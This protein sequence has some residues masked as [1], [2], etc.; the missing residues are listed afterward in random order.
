MHLEG[1]QVN[2]ALRPQARTRE[3]AHFLHLQQVS[4]SSLQHFS[5]TAPVAGTSESKASSRVLPGRNTSFGRHACS[6]KKRSLRAISSQRFT[7]V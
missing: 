2:G 7:W 6:V 3:Q 5:K 1:V 4:R